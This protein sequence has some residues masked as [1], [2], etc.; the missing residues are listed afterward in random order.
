MQ[1][2]PELFQR[3]VRLR[4]QKFL[5]PCDILVRKEGLLVAV[6][7]WSELSLFSVLG[8]PAP[9]GTGTDAENFGHLAFGIVQASDGVHSL[10]AHF[11]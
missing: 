1:G 3:H 7:P 4:L 8:D 2:L 9:N 5:R 11:F 10:L 6:R